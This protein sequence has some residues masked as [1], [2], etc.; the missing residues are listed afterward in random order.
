MLPQEMVRTQL[1]LVG[2]SSG[3]IVDEDEGAAEQVIE[4][5]AI[6]AQVIQGDAAF[7]AIANGKACFATTRHALRWFYFDD[8]GPV[9]CEQ[10]RTHGTGVAGGDID[11][12]HARPEYRSGSASFRPRACQCAS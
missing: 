4:R 6:C 5:F 8:I 12:E 9:F 11:H 10:L 7:G 1:V 3:K 2:L